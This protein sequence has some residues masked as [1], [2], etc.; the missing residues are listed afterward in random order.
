VHGKKTNTYKAEVQ[1]SERI[2]PLGITRSKLEN[3]IKME[4]NEV[5]LE[6]PE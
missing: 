1:K 2:K 3:N 5:R 4:F 6:D